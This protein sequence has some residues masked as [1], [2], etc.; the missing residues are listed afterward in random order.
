MIYY[1]IY[2]S[3]KVFIIIITTCTW[4]MQTKVKVLKKDIDIVAWKNIISFEKRD[5]VT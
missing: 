1:I 4:S 2:N 3:I 5:R